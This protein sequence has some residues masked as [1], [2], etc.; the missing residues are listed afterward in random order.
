ML[1]SNHINHNPPPQKGNQNF[2]FEK[3]K[4]VRCVLV[5]H[6][7]RMNHIVHTP[8]SDFFLSP[9]LMFMK[10]IYVTACGCGLHSH[11]YMSFHCVNCKHRAYNFTITVLLFWDIGQFPDFDYCDKCFYEHSIHTCWHFCW[12]YT[13]GWNCQVSGCA[14]VPLWQKQSNTPSEWL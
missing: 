9:N 6:I 4:L 2:H 3:Q 5:V 7:S 13:Q 11:C 10:F 1:S 12:A 14:Y 8:V